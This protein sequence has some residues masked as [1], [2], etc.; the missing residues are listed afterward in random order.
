MNSKQFFSPASK[1]P[2]R[3]LSLYVSSLSLKPEIATIIQSA[4]R[5]LHLSAGLNRWMTAGLVGH[6]EGSSC[7]EFQRGPSWER[8]PHVVCQVAVSS[9]PRGCARSLRT[10][11]PALWAPSIMPVITQVSSFLG[12]LGEE[13]LIALQNSFCRNRCSLS[14]SGDF[15]EGVGWGKRREEKEVEG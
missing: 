8:Q 3:S 5:Q 11:G 12:S 1:N 9:R 15:G 13:C 4:K 2:I 6:L 14:H 10:P 7:S